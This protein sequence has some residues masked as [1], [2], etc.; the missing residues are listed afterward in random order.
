MNWKRIM[1][2]FAAF[3]IIGSVAGGYVSAA[4]TNYDYS[5]TIDG[6]TY[7]QHGNFGKWNS[8]QS[9]DGFI[10]GYGVEVY[11]SEG[12]FVGTADIIRHSKNTHANSAQA[13][14]WNYAQAE[15][16]VVNE[17]NTTE[18]NDWNYTDIEITGEQ[19]E[20]V[21]N[22]TEEVNETEIV[23][24][25]EVVN[26]TTEDQI[27]NVTGEVNETTE[28]VVNNVTEPVNETNT[29]EEVADD[30]TGIEMEKTGGAISLIIAAIIIIAVI[31]VAVRRD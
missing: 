21:N 26:E 7:Y 17:T 24:E 1:S 29:T 13:K 18:E 19:E 6:V 5:Y 22:V 2:I 28:E 3:I 16:E 4:K 12:N 20:P 23:N 14:N 15:P 25:T 9:T 27:I 10:C 30:N 11:D 31:A 8:H